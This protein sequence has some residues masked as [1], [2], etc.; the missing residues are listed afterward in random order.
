MFEFPVWD[1]NHKVGTVK[2]SCSGLYYAYEAEIRTSKSDFIRLYAHSEN[3]SIKLGLFIWE[4]AVLHCHGRISARSLKNAPENL[5][6]SLQNEPLLYQNGTIW[7]DNVLLK[8][9]NGRRFVSIRHEND[10]PEEIMPYFCF[11][12]PIE[13]DGTNFLGFEIDSTEKPVF[14]EQF[15]K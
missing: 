12:H 13:I 7:G 8:T 5:R 9:A 4:G 3:E 11:L 2:F 6:Y 14:F 15:K 1:Q 10:L